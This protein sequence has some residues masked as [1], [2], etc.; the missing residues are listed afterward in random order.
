MSNKKTGGS[1]NKWYKKSG[2]AGEMPAIPGEKKIFN[3]IFLLYQTMGRH[4]LFCGFIHKAPDIM[5]YD[6]KR[7]FKTIKI[8]LYNKASKIKLYF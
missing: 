1:V 6:E 8:L 5:F 7:I 4:H 3:T 2:S